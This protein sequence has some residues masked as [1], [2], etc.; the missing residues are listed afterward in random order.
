MQVG[1]AKRNL[2]FHLH[3]PQASATPSYAASRPVF[4]FRCHNHETVALDGFYHPKMNELRST[5]TVS[6]SWL[7][8]VVSRTTKRMVPE[9]PVFS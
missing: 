6:P 9:R 8:T 3:T 2:T 7:V 1:L 4:A 5:A